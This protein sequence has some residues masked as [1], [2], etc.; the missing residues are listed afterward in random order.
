MI[1]T[2]P[3]ITALFTIAKQWNQHSSPTIDEWT[4]KMWYLYTI[5]YYSVIKK[6]E[7]MLFAGKWMA[8]EIMILSEVSEAQKAKYHIFVHNIGLK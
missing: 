5:K 3:F 4:K 6:N 7:I 1:P 2:H 8:L